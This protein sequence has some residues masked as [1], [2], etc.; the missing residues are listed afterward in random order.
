MRDSSYTVCQVQKLR[1]FTAYSACG[2]LCVRG[3]EGHDSAYFF[4]NIPRATLTDDENIAG[5]G[6]EKSAKT[7]V[8][9]QCQ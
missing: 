1:R 6:S 7:L 4:D 9:A 2:A 8:L 3:T 5:F